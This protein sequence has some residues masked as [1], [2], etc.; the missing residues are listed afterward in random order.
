MIR[1]RHSQRV[2]EVKPAS[3]P[4]VSNKRGDVIKYWKM[5]IRGCV[6]CHSKTAGIYVAT[7][8]AV[9]YRQRLKGEKREER[10]K[11]DIC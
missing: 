1:W 10:R 11:R 8:G 4:Q 5:L 6:C 3:F 7:G 9:V 2:L